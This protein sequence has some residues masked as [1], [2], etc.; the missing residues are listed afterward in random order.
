MISIQR[1]WKSLISILGVIT[2]LAVILLYRSY[3]F[4]RATVEKFLG[5]SLRFLKMYESG[6]E[7][8]PFGEKTACW[9]F[10]FNVKDASDEFIIYTSFLGKI[11]R[12]SPHKIE[13]SDLIKFEKEMNRALES[14]SESGADRGSQK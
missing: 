6:V 1:F 14:W 7:I 9:R 12:M 2:V 8:L 13:K 5:S 10:T 4:S 3:L 11:T